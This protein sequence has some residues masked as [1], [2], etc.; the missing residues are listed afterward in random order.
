VE[1]RRNPTTSTC[2]RVHADD[3]TTKF[4]P[5]GEM[6]KWSSYCTDQE[7]KAAGR[8]YAAARAETNAGPDAYRDI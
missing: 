2:I 4:A 5:D 8:A 3:K 1:Y 6:T 7:K